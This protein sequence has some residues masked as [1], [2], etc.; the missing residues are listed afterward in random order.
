MAKEDLSVKETIFDVQKKAYKELINA[1][2]LDKKAR[3][4]GKTSPV[5]IDGIYNV[6]EWLKKF[7]L[8]ALIWFAVAVI[9]WKALTPAPKKGHHGINQY[10]ERY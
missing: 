3:E 7:W 10:G 9:V 4:V 1:L 6:K 8:I 5:P 2:S